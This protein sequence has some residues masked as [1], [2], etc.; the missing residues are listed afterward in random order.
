MSKIFPKIYKLWPK[1]KTKFKVAQKFSPALVNIKDK[2]IIDA[3]DRLLNLLFS[4]AKEN[5]YKIHF[6]SQKAIENKSFRED[7]I[8]FESSNDFFNHFYISYNDRN[9]LKILIPEY[10]FKC[11]DNATFEVNVKELMNKVEEKY[12]N[13]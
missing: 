11:I 10:Y 2:D 3:L 5:D 12:K 7:L 4:K 13:I 1:N 8:V 6:I 9:I